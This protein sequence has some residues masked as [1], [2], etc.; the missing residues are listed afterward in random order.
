M[1]EK[2]LVLVNAG[3]TLY[4]VGL[5]WT[6]QVVHYPLFAEVGGE[7]YVQYQAGH[8]WR[9]TTIVLVPMVLELGTAGL[10][11]LMMRKP[12]AIVAFLLVLVVWASTF[13]LQVPAHSILD[14]GF[15]AVAHNQLVSTNWVR[16]IAWTMRGG[17]S[18]W[19]IWEL[20]K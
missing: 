14:R 1:G 3:V 11:M 6:I 12:L 13:F 19:W 4:L 5:I 2:F 8:Q 18:L 15:D 9:I 16:T 10:L 20:I 17:I 7:S